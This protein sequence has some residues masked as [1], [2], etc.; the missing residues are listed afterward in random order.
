MSVD[1]QAGVLALVKSTEGEWYRTAALIEEA[2]SAVRLIR[3]EWSTLETAPDDHVKALV[4]RVTQDDLAAARALIEEQQDRGIRLA[5]VLDDTYPA[6]LSAIYNRPPF[7]WLRGDIVSADR[8]S[9]AIVG[10]RR[11]SEQ[12][13]EYGRWFGQELAKREVTVLSGLAR[14]IDTAAHTAALDAGGRTVAVL[15][16]GLSRPVYPPENGSLADRIATQGAL[17][18]QFWPDAPPTRYSFPMRNVV[19]SG[20]A[21]GTVVVEASE[22]SGAKMQGRLCLEHGKR[23]FLLESLV[24]REAWAQAYAERP[25]ATIVTDVED[26]IEVLAELAAEPEQLALC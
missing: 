1:E 21:V 9:I 16:H 3:R 25:G 23:L 24:A 15:G 18:S 26:I 2:G 13:L 19:M 20:M 22:T 8:R 5:T 11:A 4:A 6:N 17:V 10:T 7:I 14:G 12:G